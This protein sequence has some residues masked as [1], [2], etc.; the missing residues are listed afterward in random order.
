M[1]RPK[2]LRVVL[3]KPSK[4][5][6]DGWVERFRWG[7]MPN[8]S[9]PYLASLTPREL[10]GV[11]VEVHA[12][13]EYVH[14]D[15][16]YLDLLEAEPGHR[17]LLGLVGIQSHQF[18]RALDLAALASQRGALAILGGPHP[19][20][21]D[22]SMIHGRGPSFALSEAERIWEQVLRDAIEHGEL[23]PSYGGDARWTGTLDPPVLQPPSSADLRRYASRLLGIYPA[24]G[25][26]YRC[27]FCSI[28][29][30]AGR[31]V[32]SQPLETTLASLRAAQHA[33]AGAIFFTS[34]N[35]N[36]YPEATR[37]LDAMIDEGLQLPFI[38][39]CDL[40]VYRQGELIEKLGRAGCIQIYL[41]MESF[42]RQSLLEV[43]K[44]QNRPEHYRDVRQLCR[45]HG[46]ACHFTNILGF[47][48]HTEE[49]ILE[50][51]EVLRSFDPD[52]ASFYILTPLPGTEQYDDFM[53]RG[54]VTERN[55]DRFDASHL[56]FDHPHL[57]HE[58]LVDLA[59]RCYREFYDLR[60]IFRHVAQLLHGASSFKRGAFIKNV[61]GLAMLSR[62]ASRGSL[63]GR[64][65]M[66]LDFAGGLFR[67]K[68]DRVSDYL[69]LR[70]ETYG[71]ELAPLPTSLRLSAH[72]EELNRQAKLRVID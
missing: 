53:A 43:Q 51:L 12:I 57:S 20:T 25:C 19:M 46:I 13:D 11:P 38:V 21:C 72:D 22:T 2:S 34:D 17:T 44:L 7:S 36:K 47:M 66:T 39:Q 23:A 62:R 5:N 49:T 32:R 41:G 6:T 64:R 60:S 15:L 26:P 9:L 37:L 16:R 1:N 54:L 45:Q 28:I 3:I 8:C 67:R 18:H 68:V 55:L 27:S 58:R 42:D 50:H 70:R 52:L 24:R 35:F 65:E 48:S 59:Y 4:Y 33:G 56:T 69:D 29:K 63:S 10:L 71:F 61:F 40:Q 31:Q 14:T 30:I